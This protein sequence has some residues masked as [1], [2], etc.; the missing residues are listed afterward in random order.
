MTSNYTRSVH[1]LGTVTLSTAARPALLDNVTST[2]LTP[3]AAIIRA[4]IVLTFV[5]SMLAGGA[6][7]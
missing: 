7:V 4:G 2:G 5:P 6:A 3:T 1:G